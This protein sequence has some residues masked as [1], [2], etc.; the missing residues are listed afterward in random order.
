MNYLMN[1]L[2]YAGAAVSVVLLACVDNPV[3]PTTTTSALG[4]SIPAGKAWAEGKEI[5]FMHTEI[6]DPDIA[7]TLTNM[8][9]SPV[10]VVPSL[11]QLPDSLL[12]DVY[13]FANGLKGAGPLKYQS[14]V[15]DKPPS[16][17]GYTP[18]RRLKVVS[19]KDT[20]V[21]RLLKSVS[22]IDQAI[23]AGEITV[24]KKPVVINMPFVVWA[25]NQ[26]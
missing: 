16:T 1:A 15:F 14:D 6:S 21:A 12:A 19:W 7:I 4:Y 23:T 26:R 22:E 9:K 13:V 18:L 5:R 25:D 3:T 2:L 17:A 10:L 8:M 20:T 24:E 11:A